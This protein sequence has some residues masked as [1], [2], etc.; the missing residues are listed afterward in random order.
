MDAHNQSDRFRYSGW[1]VRIFMTWDHAERCCA[2][3]AELYEGRRIRCRIALQRDFQ[4]QDDAIH[5]LR[6]RAKQY[7]EDWKCRE[8]SAESEFSEL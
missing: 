1:I 8:H 3:R 6:T 5:S 4:H 7:I 2:G